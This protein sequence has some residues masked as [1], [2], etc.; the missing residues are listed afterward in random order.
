MVI[1]YSHG[2][3]CDIGYSLDTLLDLAFN[4]KV[5]VF[6]YE[7]T[8]YGQSTGNKNDIEIIKCI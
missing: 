4:L 5:N 6:A 8:G 1:L 7:Y 2:N 3:S